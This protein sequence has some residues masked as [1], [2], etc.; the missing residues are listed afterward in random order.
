MREHRP[1]AAAA[2][3][4]QASSALSPEQAPHAAYLAALAYQE[5]GD[6]PSAAKWLAIS[7]R[8]GRLDDE[9]SP[10]FSGSVEARGG[11]TLQVGAFRQ[12]Q[13]AE[14]AAADAS[15]VADSGGHGPVRIV[16]IRDERRR[17]LYLVQFGRFATRGS[18]ADAR[19][20]LGNLRF[21][22]APLKLPKSS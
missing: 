22:V 14:H 2:Q 13:H 9:R 17:K 15:A 3:F 8:N 4:E 7:Q 21:I 19:T 6:K 20:R 11:F 18:A 10:G 1:L 12:R 5:A 16:P